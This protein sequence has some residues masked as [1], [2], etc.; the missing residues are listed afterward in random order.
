[1]QAKPSKPKKAAGA[2]TAARQKTKPAAPTLC[3]PTGTGPQ[4]TQLPHCKP[5]TATGPSPTVQTLATTAEASEAAEGQ[6]QLPRT[7]QPLGN[8]VGH[9]TEDNSNRKTDA[10]AWDCDG[11]VSAGDQDTPMMDVE[12]TPPLTDCGLSVAQL[13]AQAGQAASFAAQ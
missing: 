1:M 6:P 2:A 5:A 11:D 13:A 12:E 10:S 3:A 9:A 7:V 4:Q 8:A